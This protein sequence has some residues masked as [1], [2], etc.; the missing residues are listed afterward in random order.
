MKT[1]AVSFIVPI[2]NVE[3]YLSR[4]VNSLRNQTLQDIEIILVDDESPDNCPQMCD[5]FASE[6]TRIRVIHKKN[7]GAGFSRNAG[8]DIAAG[9]YIYFVD[10]DDYIEFNAAELLY[11]EAK[12][13]N[14]DICFAGF[15]SEDGNYS[16]QIHI[17]NDL[18]VIEGNEIVD[19]VLKEYLGK[20]LN[21]NE[22][23]S[24]AVWQGL[25]S[26]SLISNNKIEFLSERE[27]ISE[28][29]FF[30]IDIFTKAKRFKYVK[31]NIYH[32][33]KDENSLSH[34]ADRLA[35]YDMCYLLEIEKLKGFPNYSELLSRI[36]SV[37]IGHAIGYLKSIV[38]SPNGNIINKIE[39]FIK[40]TIL[41]EIIRNYPKN[42]L[43][44]KY[45]LFFFL[46]KKNRKRSIYLLFKL[47]Y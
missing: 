1:P 11:N 17:F 15:W 42:Y 32:H 25:I 39:T 10:S 45:K 46:I 34:N 2:Y 3:K 30:L 6:D 41:H 27:V 24:T 13:N 14:L 4:C 18:V 20:P 22:K 33:I 21:K 12:L 28:D 47:F 5:Q 40:N 23:S 43:P 19:T 44:F 8:L 31:A 9:E 38:R 26:R 29:T 36:Q 37:Y 16:H 35:K 7:S